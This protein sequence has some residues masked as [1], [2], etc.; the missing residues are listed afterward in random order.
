M[1]VHLR[2]ARPDEADLVL[3]WRADPRIRGFEEDPERAGEIIEVDGQPVG[4]IDPHPAYAPACQALLGPSVGEHPWTLDLLVVPDFWGRGI[5]R[6]AIR[7]VSERC[8]SGEATSMV[9]D[10]E[11]GRRSGRSETSTSIRS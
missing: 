5:G 10:V 1:K 2:P 11:V 8:L 4:W 7:S 3:T 9:V 6:G